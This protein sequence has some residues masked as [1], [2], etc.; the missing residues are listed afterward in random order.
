MKVKMRTLM[1]NPDGVFEPG[2]VHD[3]PDAQ[4]KALISGNN[5]VDMATAKKEEETEKA[6]RSESK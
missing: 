2:T 4:A 1:V 3:F 5:A 6:K